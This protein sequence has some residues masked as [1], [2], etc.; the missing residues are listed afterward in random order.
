M[1]EDYINPERLND[2]VVDSNE[3]ENGRLSDDKFLEFASKFA[4]ESNDSNRVSSMENFLGFQ[5]ISDKMCADS[6]E[7]ILEACVKRIG[8]ERSFKV[9][10]MLEILPR[11]TGIDISKILQQRSPRIP[12]NIVDGSEDADLSVNYETIEEKIG[13]R[14]NDRSYLLEALTH[15]SYTTKRVTG[16]YQRLEFLGD[17]VLDML[18]T[19]FIY[20]RCQNIDPGQFTDKRSALVNNETLACICVRHE[21]H[22]HI[23]YQN[24]WLGQAIANFVQHQH[25]HD[26]RVNDMVNVLEANM[27]Y[28]IDVPKSLGDVFEAIIGAIFLDCGNDL[29]VLILKQ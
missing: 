14:F 29:K 11:Q 21:I 8:V 12:M 27:A 19:F 17:A 15:S 22:E 4:N 7:A 2:L 18:V 20:E 24:D 6:I 25:E 1:K 28:C 23:L 5:T 26:N 9:L 10:E 13:Y 16:C 3:L